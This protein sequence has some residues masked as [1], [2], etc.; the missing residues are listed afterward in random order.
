MAATGVVLLPD[1]MT[2][3]ILGGF[4]PSEAVNY[5]M[6]VMFLIAGGTRRGAVTALLPGV[7]RLTDGRRVTA[8]S[9]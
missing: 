6:L 8:Q 7:C 9:P 4:P 2:G 5:Q 1:M 3:K